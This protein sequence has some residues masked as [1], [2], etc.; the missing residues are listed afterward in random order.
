MGKKYNLAAFLVAIVAVS[1]SKEI[2]SSF[3]FET[4][5]G[6]LNTRSEYKSE[7]DKYFITKD[8]A[9]YYA[10][11]IKENDTLSITTVDEIRFK[12]VSCLY[13]INFNQGWIAIPTDMRFQPIV[14]KNAISS[15]NPDDNDNPGL[16]A[17]LGAMTED[18]YKVR[19]EGVSKFDNGIVKMWTSIIVTIEEDPQKSISP[20]EATWVRVPFVNTHSSVNANVDR[21]ISTHWGQKWPWNCSL[22]IIPSTDTTRFVTGCVAT[23]VSQILYYYHYHFGYPNDMFQIITPA[24]S[25]STIDGGFKLTL[26]K[27]GYTT[28]SSRW[29]NMPHTVDG[30]GSFYNVSDLMML[31]G[32]KMNATYYP[33]LKT[34][35]PLSFTNHLLQCNISSQKSNYN[36][37]TVKNNL[38]NGNPVIVTADQAPPSNLGHAWIIDG[39]YDSETTTDY[40]YIYYQFVPGTIYPP[41]SQ[42]ISD[43]DV[44][45]TYPYAYDGMS[46]L[47]QSNTY[48]TQY[49][50]MNY[51]WADYADFGQYYINGNG[52]EEGLNNNIMIFYNLSA[53]QLGN[54]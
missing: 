38:I 53:G 5:T 44:Y 9:I 19:T 15:L 28:H 21:L 3:D 24:I 23:A 47:T 32:V 14:G 22:P 31:V 43:N 26:S 34:A 20:E 42:Y 50:R 29:S 30:S 52:W 48:Q 12:G 25:G 46:I 13:I 10:K 41:G 1:C 6:N 36:Y 33:D 27:S 8:M 2:V 51:G 54:N 40:Y 45:G 4:K 11:S 17:W 16:M 35:T 18:V 7:S 37:T 49:L 39:C